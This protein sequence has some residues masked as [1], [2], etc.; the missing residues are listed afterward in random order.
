MADADAEQK[1]WHA[2]LNKLEETL[3]HAIMQRAKPC[4]SDQH[5]LKLAFRAFDFTE[6]GHGTDTG[7]VSYSEFC[8]AMER[9]G[10]YASVPVRGLFD[11]YNADGAE[12]L[13]YAVFSDGLYGD[14]KPWPPPPKR[15]PEDCK[16][17][18]KE[19]LRD[20]PTNSWDTSV[21]TLSPNKRPVRVLSIA[22]E[23]HRTAAAPKWEGESTSWG[24]T[25][26]RKS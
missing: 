22:N 2:E 7:F 15:H 18:Q 21:E 17:D 20:G 14:E 26:T 24:T 13:S 3:R 9:F 25:Y 8:K 1:A 6:E 10:L 5:T 4:M 12:D 19:W 23:K 11:R 16:T